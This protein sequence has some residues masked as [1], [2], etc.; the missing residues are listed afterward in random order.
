MITAP[1]SRRRA[2]RK[3][4]RAGFGS[5]AGPASRPWSSPRSRV[6]ML[7]LSSTGMPSSGDR[8][9]PLTAQPLR[10]GPR[11]SAARPGW[12]VMTACSSRV[13][14][15]D[16]AQ[17]EAGS[18]RPRGQPAVVHGPLQVGDGRRLQ[19]DAVQHRTHGGRPP[20]GVDRLRRSR[21]RRADKPGGD[22]GG[23]A[24]D[25]HGTERGRSGNSHT[26][27]READ[28][29]TGWTGR[30]R[31]MRR[32]AGSSC[33]CTGPVAQPLL[34]SNAGVTVASPPRPRYPVRR[35]DVRPRRRAVTRPPSRCCERVIR[36]RYGARVA[37]PETHEVAPEGGIRL[38]RRPLLVVA[39]AV[40]ALLIATSWRYGYHRDELYF[41]ASEHHLA[42]SYPDQG[43]LYP[44]T[45]S[46]HGRGSAPGSLTL[47]RLPS[48]LAAGG[49]VLLT[50]M[51][52]RE[53]GAGRRA[54]TIA[55]VVAA[56]APVIVLF[57][58]HTLSTA[59]FDLLA[60]AAVTWL[61]GPRGPHPAMIGSGCWSRRCSAPLDLLNKP[62]P[63]VPRRG[64]PGRDRRG[65]AAA[66]AALPVSLAR[67]GGN[68][69]HAVVTMADLASHPWLAAA[70][71]CPAR[72]PPADRPAPH[73]GGRSP[74]SRSR[75]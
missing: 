36:T 17:V 32:P 56:V 34:R 25:G 71:G 5:A 45:C 52:A 38:A 74:P 60:W 43:P 59:T 57:T 23:D 47:L 48:A 37:V 40:T 63:G 18:A 62:L 6:S 49:T 46:D 75:C 58:G 33:T 13:E 65:R 41:L 64:D 22:S 8:T 68:R 24:D 53:F 2:A 14:G 61:A 16:A 27:L 19:A 55:A 51:L 12:S 31:G 66:A 3:A 26:V 67:S 50:S 42:W 15:A 28:S 9:T 10:L 54:Q 35:R 21:S 73:R 1:A 4:S 30:R 44:T 20:A 7:S 72:S 11:R 70:S 39:G 29:G 69:H